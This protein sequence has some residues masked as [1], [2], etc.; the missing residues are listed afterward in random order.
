M[1]ASE[2]INQRLR[3]LL[4]SGQKV[5]STRRPPPPNVLTDDYVDDSG[6]Q[7]WATSA[8]DMLRRTFGAESEYYQRFK[9]A[10]KHTGYYSDMVRGVAIIKA[11]SNDFSK[12]YLAET[13]ALVRA[14][15]F[16]DLL[17]QS[18]Y[19][20]SQGFYQ[21]AAVLAGGVLEDALRQLCR[22]KQHW[23]FGQAKA[24]WYEFRPH[25]KGH[26]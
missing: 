16:G 9:G 26:L 25:E 13:A 8:A 3:E 18:E 21:A 14:E 7:E 17:E 11:A 12:G 6:S 5:L 10:F 23:H 22:K 1:K 15:V 20:L 19:L 2:L 24:R 4:D